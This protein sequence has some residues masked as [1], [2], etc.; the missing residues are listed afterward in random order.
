MYKDRTEQQ[1]LNKKR[2]ICK[3]LARYL[4]GMSKNLKTENL[5]VE[6]QIPL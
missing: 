4:V 3:D 5:E 2:W 6:S 1:D